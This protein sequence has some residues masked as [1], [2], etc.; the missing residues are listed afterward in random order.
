VILSQI[1]QQHEKHKDQHN[2]VTDIEKSFN[3][4]DFSSGGMAVAPECVKV[5]KRLA[6][7]ISEECKEP[8]LHIC[9]KHECNFVVKCGGQLGVKPI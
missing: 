9:R 1:Y 4:L 6:E 2:K 8:Y 3:P 7:K 5:N